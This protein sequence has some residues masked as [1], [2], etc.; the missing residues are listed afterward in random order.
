MSSGKWRQFCLGLRL[1]TYLLHP[2]PSGVFVLHWRRGSD[3]IHIYNIY[4]YA[5]GQWETSLHCNDVSHWL[6][7]YLNWSLH[8]VPISW[9]A[10]THYTWFYHSESHKYK[11]TNINRTAKRQGRAVYW[12]MWSPRL[13]RVFALWKDEPASNKE[14]DRSPTSRLLS[15]I[16]CWMFV[17]IL[18]NMMHGLPWYC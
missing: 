1:G 9:K 12:L 14:T 5:P 8:I 10:I 4:I 18:H 15:I 3:K 13:H 6:G 16:V 17:N 7:A 2:H 11:H